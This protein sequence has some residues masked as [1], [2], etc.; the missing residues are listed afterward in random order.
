MAKVFSTATRDIS[1]P[2]DLLQVVLI[3]SSLPIPWLFGAFWSTFERTHMNRSFASLIAAAVAA[4][5]QPDYRRSCSLE[6]SRP[7][8]TVVIQYGGRPC[9]KQGGEALYRPLVSVLHR[10][11]TGVRGGTVPGTPPLSGGP[12]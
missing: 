7:R 8:L 11:C 6:V 3:Q 1:I 2:V 9:I 12:N 4:T 5:P 10:Y